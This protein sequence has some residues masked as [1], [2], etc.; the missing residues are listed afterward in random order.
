[1]DSLEREQGG[2]ETAGFL[3]Q[4]PLYSLPARA[5]AQIKDRAFP[6]LKYSD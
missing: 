5:V 2:K 3:L 6:T 1:M 4:C